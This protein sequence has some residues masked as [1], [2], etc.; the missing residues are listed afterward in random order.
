MNKVYI[1]SADNIHK[2]I[3]KGF[4]ESGLDKRLR[5]SNTVFIKPN[6]VTDVPEY[7]EN[8]ANTDTR[9]IE[10]ILKYL[11]RF[12]KLKVLLGESDTGSRVKGR[13]LDLALKYMGVYEL[14]DKYNFEIVNLT[15]DEQVECSIPEGKFIKKLS[16]SKKFLDSDLIINIPKIKTHKYA[17]ITCA[18]KNMF[19][20]IPDPMRVIYHQNIHQ[21]LADLNS[22][23]YEKIFVITDGICGME[24]DGPLYGQPVNLNIIMFS[25]QAIYNDVVAG[26]IMGIKPEEVKHIQLLNDGFLNLDLEDYSIL[27][28][29]TVKDLSIPFKRAEKNLFI[30]IEG[31]LMQYPWVVRILFNDWFREH[32]TYHINPILKKLRGG[33]YSWYIKK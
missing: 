14:Q 21:V 4:L 5:L 33:S 3:E 15:K 2:T 6:L 13:K 10:G 11:S 18:L 29:K 16:L 27:G 30:Q 22:M 7:I 31:R 1:Y 20:T 25:E 9:V 28:D 8:G 12:P 24:G 32:I 26:K 23:F 19:G 17:T